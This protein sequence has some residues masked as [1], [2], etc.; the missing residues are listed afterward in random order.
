M[1]REGKK[2]KIESGR[3]GTFSSSSR[4]SLFLV[5][6]AAISHRCPALASIEHSTSLADSSQKLNPCRVSLPTRAAKARNPIA[7][8]TGLPYCLARV[9]FSTIS[10]EFTAKVVIGTTQFD[11]HSLTY[12]NYCSFSPFC[13]LLLPPPTFPAY[14]PPVCYCND[15]LPSAFCK[16]SFFLPQPLSF[17]FFTAP[18]AYLLIRHLPS[19]SPSFLVLLFFVPRLTMPIVTVTPDDSRLLQEIADSIANSKRAIVVTGAGIST[20]CGIPVRYHHDASQQ[21]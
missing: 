5:A 20:N 4:I 3:T 9:T 13:S 8:A 1:G 7:P 2:S 14:S 15:Q 19:P 12:L 16:H 17:S 10:L 21:P 6:G 18:H 11:F